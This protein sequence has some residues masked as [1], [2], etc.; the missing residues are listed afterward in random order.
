MILLLDRISPPTQRNVD[1]RLFEH[2]IKYLGY[3][4]YLYKVLLL[5]LKYE[6]TLI[7]KFLLLSMHRSVMQ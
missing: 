4:S 2:G 6:D 1:H 3:I 5:H 7:Y